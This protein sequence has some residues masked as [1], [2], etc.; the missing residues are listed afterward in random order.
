MI[1]YSPKNW[2]GLL[3]DVYSRH[4]ARILL[5]LLFFFILSSGGISYL[6]IE[7]Y[8]QWALPGLSGFHSILGVILGLFIVFRT[9]SAYEK[10][11]E[12]R[13]I[14]GSL[15]ND[16]RSFAAKISV[17]ISGERKEDRLFFTHMIPNFVYA[18][19]NHLRGK[20]IFSET[21]FTDEKQGQAF[22]KS[23]HRPNYIGFLMYSRVQSLYKE[24][25][26]SGEQLFILDKELKGFY[27]HVGACERIKNT[28]IPYSYS[29]F[30]KKCIFIYGLTIPFAFIHVVGYWNILIV[31][32]A[33]YFLIS[34]EVI[35]EEIEEPF[36][37]DINDLPLERLSLTIKTNVEEII[38]PQADFKLYK[39]SKKSSST[40]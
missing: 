24:K 19:K 9:N 36:G 25:H 34:I 35:A 11:W 29:V 32:I 39:R 15:V 1:K 8:P 33:M 22:K 10:W 16:S 17:F 13:K 7:H 28:P 3:F 12:G 6:V 27:D 14:W 38:T 37:L 5:P 4:V 20:P 23:I 31:L 18:M 30:I 26:I 2:V 21:N 40:S